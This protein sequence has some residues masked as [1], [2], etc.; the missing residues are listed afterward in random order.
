M[1]ANLGIIRGYLGD[2]LAHRSKEVGMIAEEESRTSE[3]F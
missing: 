3:N 1:N 2:W